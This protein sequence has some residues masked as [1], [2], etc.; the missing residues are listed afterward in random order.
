M[1]TILEYA[2]LSNAIYSDS[3]NVRGWAMV[4]QRTQM[5]SGLIAGVS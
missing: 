1:I 5:P 4:G 2:K 3:P